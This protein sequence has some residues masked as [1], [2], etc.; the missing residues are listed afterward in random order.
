MAKK[1]AAERGTVKPLKKKGKSCPLYCLFLVIFFAFSGTIKNN[2]R[3]VN[4]EEKE[5]YF[6]TRIHRSVYINVFRYRIKSNEGKKA[7]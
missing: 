4:F 3:A 6:I 7:L 1:A 5:K 2:P